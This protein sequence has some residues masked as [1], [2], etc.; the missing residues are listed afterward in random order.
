MKKLIFL[1]PLLMTLNSCEKNE[2][3]AASDPQPVRRGAFYEYLISPSATNPSILLYNNKHYVCVDTRTT[4]KNKLFV[5]FPG[6]SGSPE[7]YKLIVKRA[8]ALGYHAIGLMYPNGSEIYSWSA[9]NPDNT[10]FGKCRQEI[11][12]GTN[13]TLG[14]TVDANN[15]IKGRLVKLLQYLS[16]RYPGLNYQQFL[17]GND[18]LWNK[19]ILGGHSQGGGHA[20]YIAKKVTVD[21]TIAFASIDWN[22]YLN[23]SADWVSQAGLTAVNRFYSINSTRDEVFAYANVQT[24]L[25]DMGL[26][27]TATSIDNNSSPYGGTNKLTTSTNAAITVLV[28]NHN[29]TCLDAYVPKTSTGAVTTSMQNAWNYLINY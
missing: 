3:S 6:T 9:S 12:D 4:L 14:V 7:F 1:F 29:V 25:A 20:F 8:A 10:Q 13:Q 18:V 5:F 23:R 17:N 27:G 28:P 26:P 11:F 16:A 19:C 2:E 15:C 22:T 24:Q 21:K